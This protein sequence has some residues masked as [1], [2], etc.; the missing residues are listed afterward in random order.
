M[1]LAV[2]HRE[3]ECCSDLARE[4]SGIA[5]SRRSHYDRV[6]PVDELTNHKNFWPS[7]Q[8]AKVANTL[9][10]DEA[11]KRET[12]DNNKKTKQNERP[13]GLHAIVALRKTPH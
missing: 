10:I 7:Y 11:S 1:A 9:A 2:S 3:R 4:S 6:S 13:D 8:A 5:A 12:N